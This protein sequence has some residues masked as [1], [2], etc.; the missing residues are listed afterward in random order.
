MAYL[1]ENGL[2]QVWAKTKAITPNITTVGSG[3]T[4]IDVTPISGGIQ[5]T[6]G[7][8]ASNNTTSSTITYSQNQAALQSGN[9]Y[10]KKLSGSSNSI[11]S[12]AEVTAKYAHSH[13]TCSSYCLCNC[14]GYCSC[15]CDDCCDNR[16]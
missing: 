3:E 11:T 8:L 14:D 10:V 5:V 1:D 12:L 4:V 9:L 16:E 13:S 15:D 6:Y 7:E 2:S